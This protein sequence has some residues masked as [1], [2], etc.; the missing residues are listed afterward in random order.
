MIGEERPI[1]IKLTN[2]GSVDW[3]YGGGLTAYNSVEDALN[4]VP[5]SLR[6]GKTVGVL[7]DGVVVEY[8]FKEGIT[9]EDLIIKSTGGSGIVDAYT[10]SQSDNKYQVKGAYITGV[11]SNDVT[12][13]LGYTPISGVTVDLSG[14]YTKLQADAKFLTGFTVDLSGYYT[15]SQADAKYLTGFTVD[16]SNYYD[17]SVSDSRF[18]RTGVYLTG[19]T[20]SDV[21]GA[22]GFTPVSAVT[23]DLS[24]YYTK[25]QSDAKYLTGFTVDLSS[26]YTK[27]QSDAKYLTGFTVDLSGYYTKAQ[28]DAKYLTGYTVDFSNYYNKSTA[29]GKFQPIGSYISASTLPGLATTAYVDSAVS[30]ASGDPDFMDV[31]NDLGYTVKFSTIGS[32]IQSSDLATTLGSN[33]L[34]LVVLNRIQQTTVLTG[35]VHF[36]Y[37]KGNYV[38]DDECSL[39]LYKLDSTTGVLTRVATT[40]NLPNLFKADDL[41][42]IK[43]PF[44]APY[45]AAP[46]IYFM[47]ILYGCSSQTVQPEIAGNFNVNAYIL[48]P[49][50]VNDIK[51]F[52]IK[53]SQYTSPSTVALST[54]SVNN[55]RPWAGVY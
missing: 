12:G 34:R 8:W 37:T 51:L 52:S 30:S 11:T 20:K 44:T 48:N 32:L 55:N 50:L 40:G 31:I 53:Y 6:F 28:S 25:A 14:Y 29:D 38:A 15:K 16:Y 1:G 33:Q 39:S 2:P 54:C 4:A 46:G 35:A 42:Y 24:S 17:K 41:S 45:T 36:Q 13:A 9:D 7:I 5:E 26:Y 21:T 47:G 18:Q 43:T 19:V 27:A 22:L 23:V 49:P 3:Y 10:K